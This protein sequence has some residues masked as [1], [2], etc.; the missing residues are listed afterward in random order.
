MTKS[1]RRGSSGFRS[2]QAGDRS[3]S[4]RAGECETC[5]E[6]LAPKARFCHRCGTPLEGTP[7]SARTSAKRTSVLVVSVA[8]VS[9][10]GAT[11]VAVFLTQS[12]RG[13]PTPP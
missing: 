9:V 11:L 10:I 3:K 1:K 12:N 6:T 5:G 2:R 13:G 4:A 7:V 8:A